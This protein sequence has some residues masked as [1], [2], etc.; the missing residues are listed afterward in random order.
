MSVKIIPPLER[1]EF[2]VA[3]AQTVWGKAALLAVFSALLWVGGKSWWME[4]GVI[5][6]F[7]TYSPTWRRAVI[8]LGTAYW[9]VNYTWFDREAVA[10]IFIQLDVQGALDWWRVW[11]GAFGAAFVYL[12][13]FYLLAWRLKERRIVWH[14]VAAFVGV[15]GAMLASVE[16]LPVSAAWQASAWVFVIVVGQYVWFFCYSL[17]DLQTARPTALWR[18]AGFWL[19]FWQG[20]VNTATP[21][22]KGA[23]YLNRIEAQDDRSLAV[24]QLKAIKLLVWALLLSGVYWLYKAVVYGDPAIGVF[25]LEIPTLRQAIAA[26]AAGR[27]ESW[28]VNWAALLANFF[29]DILQLAVWG[30]MVIACARFVGF[31]ALR[32]TYR[33]LASRTIAEFW[34]RYY[35][36]FKE[37]L[38]ECFFY[39]VYLRFFKKNPKLRVFAAVFA[40]AGV[41]NF[42]YHFFRDVEYIADHGFWPALYDFRVYLFYVTV[43]SVGIAVSMLR[44]LSGV[45]RSSSTSARWRGP[46]TVLSFYAVLSIFDD[47]DRSLSFTDHVIFAGRLV[48]L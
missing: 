26:S 45:V 44:S 19:P 14:P 10:D 1:Y 21:L 48:G 32:N 4:F 22:P 30:H 18:Q 46:L 43:L 3:A 37:L 24:T 2:L 31:A 9:L 39:P 11:T 28:Y 13:A 36:Y 29:R 17:I 34:N 16:L 35:Y 6:A 38:A 15:Y 23:A 33:P 8:L 20:T 41:G 5:A 27:P 12:G 40:A 42:L 47:P 7:T 25:S